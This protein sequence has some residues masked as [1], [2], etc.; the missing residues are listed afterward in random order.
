VPEG[1]A[2]FTVDYWLRRDLPAPDFLLGE[3]FSTTSRAMLVGPTGAGK[4]NLAIALNF[5]IAA[6]KDFLHWKAQWLARKLIYIDGE[7]SARLARQRL[8]QAARRHG[9]APE[10]L[11]LIN[12]DDFPNL[13]PLD[14]PEGQQFIDRLIADHC[15]MVTFD[16]V[17]SLVSGVMKDEE[18]W[19]AV[20]PG[21]AA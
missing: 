4:S 17:Q 19:A 12:R 5:A 9:T 13:P 16:N 21:F 11:L 18:P 10:N 1:A 6:G 14:T 2:K 20:L 7:M 15:D 3:L 8:Q